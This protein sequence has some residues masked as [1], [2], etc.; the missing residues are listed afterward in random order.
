MSFP[1][2]TLADVPGKDRTILL[3]WELGNGFAHAARLLWIAKRLIRAGWRPVVFAC[4]PATLRTAYEAEGI[5]VLPTPPHA[6]CFAGTPPFR[7]ASYADMMGVCGYA[8]RDKLAAIVAAWDVLLARHAPA[9]IIADYSPLLSLAAFRRIPLIPIGDGFVAPPALPDGGFPPLGAPQPDVWSPAELLANA[10]AVQERREQ[11]LPDSL[12]QIVAGIGAVV[13]IPPELDIYADWRSQPAAGPWERPEAPPPPPDAP[14]FFGYLRMSHPQAR[15]TVQALIDTGL[16]GELFL[17][18]S[19]PG[20]A[21]A[22]AQAGILLHDTPPPI[23]DALARA[24]LFIHHGGIGSLADAATTGRIQLLLPRH[25][26][27]ACNAKRALETLPG[28]FI[29]RQH[30]NAATLRAELPKLIAHRRAFRLA[31]E[32]AA[33]IAARPETAWAALQS[34]LTR[35]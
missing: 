31:Q 8:D 32:S 23:R 30:T 16:P 24:S 29:T 18:D 6:S 13:S 28:T 3:A 25:R 33:R 17:R 7:A 34:L 20:L 27:Q 11:P 12:H 1:A 5:D 19:Q 22:L 21:T 9:A 10:R 2:E 4:D 26:E 14:R 35:L 15:L